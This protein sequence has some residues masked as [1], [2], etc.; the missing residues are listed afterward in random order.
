MRS[1]EHARAPARAEGRARVGREL[2]L[3][4]GIA[5]AAAYVV[6]NDV[7]AVAMYDG[8][9]R[10]DQAVSE[11]SALAAPPRTFLTAM[12]PVFTVLMVAFGV[13]VW[14][15]ASGGRALRLTGA[16]MIAFGITGV[17]WLP[18]PMTARED[19]AAATGPMSANDVG[20]LVLSGVT[21]SLIVAMCA[22]GAAHFGRA[23]RL[24]TAATVVVVLV[25]SGVLTGLQSAKLPSGDPTPL[26]GFY[27]RLGIGAWL[28]WLT[29]LAVV[30]MRQ[31]VA[32]PGAESTRR[33]A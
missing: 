19:I 15:S 30:L 6:A 25:F 27:E 18:F 3:V 33:Q 8:Y 14:W 4:C 29:V 21:A 11:L 28:V 22:A 31:S 26:L 1:A 32:A 23:F 12:L 2:L 17:A 16:A 24:Y 20:H 9:S 5:Y 10:M 13:G 7:V